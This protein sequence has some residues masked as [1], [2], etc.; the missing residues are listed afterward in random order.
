M[1]VHRQA[2]KV[3]DERSHEIVAGEG[4]ISERGPHREVILSVGI[5]SAQGNVSNR[6]GAGG[7]FHH[8]VADFGLTVDA[9][10][11]I[12]REVASQG[13]GEPGHFLTVESQFVEVYVVDHSVHR[14]LGGLPILGFVHGGVEGNVQIGI[15]AFYPG[16]YAVTAVFSA[17][18][19]AFEGI[20][21]GFEGIDRKGIHLHA[22]TAF[23]KGGG[24]IR[25]HGGASDLVD[26]EEP[27]DIKSS[28][29]HFPREGDVAFFVDDVPYVEVGGSVS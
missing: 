15:V 22:R 10:V 7:V 3:L 13:H 18:G 11:L 2:Q 28:C 6:M 23:G 14:I 21:E 5:V 16:D 25:H 26:A 1:T 19:Y 27:S 17:S 29:G 9:A 20:S 8:E 4:H 24:K 12:D